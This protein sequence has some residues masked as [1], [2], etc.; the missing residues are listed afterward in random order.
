MYKASYNTKS[1]D[2]DMRRLMEY[3]HGFLSGVELGRTAFLNN[4]AT[5]VVEGMKQ[6]IDSMARVD[7][8]ILSHVY[9]WERV[10]SPAARL[11]DI[12]YVVSAAGIS[13]NSTFRQSTSV[14]AGSKEPFYNKARIMEAGLPV[15][16]E[17]KDATVLT[18][19]DNGE[20][21]FTKKPIVVKNPGGDNAQG[22]FE[23]TLDNFFNNYFRQSFMLSSGIIDK[24]KDMSD[25]KKNLNIGIRI[26]RSKGREI[27]YRWIVSAGVIR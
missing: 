9:E 14:K 17:V 1:F 27:G 12:N 24:L 20:Q 2:R 16:I 26:G 22:G 6:F 5:L 3:S 25:Y 21:V 18:F 19:N 7:P 4:F 10:G 23:K 11:Y 13:V 15:R 8:S